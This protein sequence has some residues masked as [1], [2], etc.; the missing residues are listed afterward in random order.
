M[1]TSQDNS[2]EPQPTDPVAGWLFNAVKGNLDR[3]HALCLEF[4]C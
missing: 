3:L 4:G 2:V 1:N